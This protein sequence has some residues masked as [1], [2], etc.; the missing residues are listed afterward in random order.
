MKPSES[1]SNCGA[2]VPANAKA[3]PACGA[4]EQTGWAEHAHAESLSLP[5]E[6]FDYDE[7]VQREFGKPAKPAGVGW[8][9]WAIGLLLLAVL[10]TLLVL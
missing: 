7:F 10:L 6:E 1:C 8:F 3:C 2:E 4:D 9:W 5:D